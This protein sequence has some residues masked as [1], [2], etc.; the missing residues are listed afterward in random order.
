MLLSIASPLTPS[1]R[2]M[3]SYKLS[4]TDLKEN[5][6]SKIKSLPDAQFSATGEK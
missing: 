1:I 4:P 5:A 2:A 3:S 6:F